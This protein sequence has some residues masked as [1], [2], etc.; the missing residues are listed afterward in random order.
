MKAVID[1]FVNNLGTIAVALVL[2]LVILLVVLKMVK[3]KKKGISSC[4]C[5][6]AGCPMSGKCHSNP[7]EK[8]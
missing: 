2:I 6:C 1:F 5:G 7:E 3:D 8:K 4:G